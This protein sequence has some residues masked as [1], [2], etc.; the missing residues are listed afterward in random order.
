MKHLIL[1][2]SS[3]TPLTLGS[4]SLYVYVLENSQR[5]I[6]IKSVQK[7][8]GYEGKNENWVFEFLKGINIYKPIAPELINNYQNPIKIY[9]NENKN[10]KYLVIT[11]NVFKETLQV[12]VNAKEEGFLNVNQIKFSKEAKTLLENEHLNNIKNAINTSTGF[13]FYK[14]NILDKIALNLKNNDLAFFWV[15]TFPNDFFELLM[16]MKNLNWKNL[17]EN[18]ENLGEILNDTIFKRIDNTLLEELRILKPKRTYNRNNSKKQDL[19][20]PK[21]KQH[22]A[23]LCSLAKISGNNWIIFNQLLNKSFPESK[24]R[25]S[26]KIKIAKINKSVT[27]SN[28]DENLLKI[29][30]AKRN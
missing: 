16:E 29:L 7:A 20:H 8:L 4:K 11:E 17:F 27:L 21:L 6:S 23:V 18:Q 5:V 13:T 2:E 28:F 24:N 22:L 10:Q 25:S 19:E 9:N 26:K 1:F 14:E 3:K 15:K 30:F 12:I